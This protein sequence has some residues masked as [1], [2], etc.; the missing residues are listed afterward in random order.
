MCKRSPITC[1]TAHTDTTMI[2]KN[3]CG[4][5]VLNAVPDVRIHARYG[6]GRS[7]RHTHN[8]TRCWTTEMINDCYR[9][10]SE[11]AAYHIEDDLKA[12]NITDAQAQKRLIRLD[13]WRKYKCR[14]KTEEL[15][16]ATLVSL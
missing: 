15:T 2:N 1:N 16:L 9:R 14:I 10:M 11:Y 12:S 3:P 13:K 7:S 5:T 6:Y 4:E 8:T